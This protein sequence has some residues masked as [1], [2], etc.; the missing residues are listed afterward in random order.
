MALVAE[1]GYT[2]GGGRGSVAS[3]SAA[4][5]MEPAALALQLAAN[6]WLVPRTVCALA[7]YWMCTFS[8]VVDE[9]EPRANAHVTQDV[10][11]LGAEL[12]YVLYAFKALL[13][14]VCG[15]H[16]TLEATAS[17]RAGGGASSS[18][19][20]LV[21]SLDVGLRARLAA[22]YD[23]LAQRRRSGP[24]G[25]VPHSYLLRCAG[26]SSVGH[27]LRAVLMRGSEMWTSALY[28]STCGPVRLT[29][30]RYDA[31]LA[32][33]YP[34]AT[35]AV[36]LC[37][38]LLRSPV[39]DALDA[40]RFTRFC[41]R[42]HAILG[43]EVAPACGMLDEL[44]APLATLAG[45][46]PLEAVRGDLARQARVYCAALAARYE[47]VRRVLLQHHGVADVDPWA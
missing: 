32:A 8:P 19:S 36:L 15:T 45:N 26:A 28:A 29:G 10:A 34:A 2:G 30:F 13:W 16:P 35:L 44:R 12:A 47:H 27:C 24:V 6:L 7:E 37:E 46:K 41:A 38:R 14:R 23:D 20:G 33:F 43:A 25:A 3:D 40:P 4:A 39:F 22:A 1:S 17:D 18:D 31:C 5:H 42:L 9:L 21:Y 11:A